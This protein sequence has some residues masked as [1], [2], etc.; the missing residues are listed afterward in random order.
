M[1]EKVNRITSLI[2]KYLEEQLSQDEARELDEWQAE[3]E[4]N[5]IFFEQITDKATL[6]EKLKIYASANS[7]AIWQK[8][9]NR[10]D[11]GKLVAMYPDKISIKKYLTVAAAAIVIV[12]AGIWLYFG[13]ANHKGIAKTDTPSHPLP[14]SIIPGS[15]KATL[16]LAD[17]STVVLNNS[18]NGAVAQ[19][20]T[21]NITQNNGRLIYK[22]EPNV[23]INQ[24]SLI[25]YNTVTTPKGG[26]YQVTLPDGSKV[27][28]NAAS[29]LRFPIAF[30]GN[31]RIVELTG[32]AYFE[33]NPQIRLVSPTAQAVAS[34][35]SVKTPFIV[36]VIGPSGN[37]N[38]VQVL[39]TH[40]NVMAYNDEEVVK[41][42]LLEGS[43]KVSSD[44]KTEILKPGQQAR[45]GKQ[46]IISIHPVN[47]EEAVAWKNGFLPVSGADI[48][49]TMRQIA[50]WYDINIEYIGKKP[51][52][53]LEGKLPR[54]ATIEDVIKVL[55]ENNIKVRL[56][57]QERK[58]IVTS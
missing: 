7:E 18:K 37:T 16:T 9:I 31:E 24:N 30:A 39:G 3:A 22:K 17:G 26:E 23:D 38:E 46:G 58:L 52:V 48:E 15:N 50:R 34:E 8:T 43:V 47:T 51:E 12:S 10:I 4:A 41:A 21:T 32:E 33:V 28:L 11:G 44:T 27:W 53:S 19:Q 49:S 29:S 40:F 1:Q 57:E 13:Q 42:T 56:E 20:G 6:R 36:K 25:A 5:R 35:K 45:L 54:T 14:N 2:E 55:N